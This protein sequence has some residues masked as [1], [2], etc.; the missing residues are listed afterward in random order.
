MLSFINSFFCLAGIV[1]CG[2]RL[3]T[4]MSKETTKG[5]IRLQ[6][7]MWLGLDMFLLIVRPLDYTHV[8]MS[9]AILLH[10][11]FTFPAWK[12]GQPPHAM[13]EPA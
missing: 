1:M 9:G 12:N 4:K 7:V 5:I 2:C 8:V 13:K 11:L 3:G 6:Y 10:L